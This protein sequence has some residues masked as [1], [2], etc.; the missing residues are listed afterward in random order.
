MKLIRKELV[1]DECRK[2]F[3]VSKSVYYRRLKEQRILCTKCHINLIGKKSEKVALGK[4]KARKTNLERYGA[5]NPSKNKII[6]EKI[7]KTNLKRYG[8]EWEITSSQ[9]RKKIEESNIRNHNVKCTFQDPIQQQKTKETLLILF[10][11]S[12][13]NDCKKERKL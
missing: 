12:Y 11:R 6:Q 8:V 1:C 5:D 9:T 4:E 7:K 2:I 3:F 13:F 10:L